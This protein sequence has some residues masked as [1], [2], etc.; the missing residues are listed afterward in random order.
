MV[1]VT[2]VEGG[3]EITNTGDIP[4]IVFVKSPD[5]EQQL[6]LDVGESVP[7][8][9]ITGPIEVLVVGEGVDATSAGH[10]GTTALFYLVSLGD[11]MPRAEQL[12]VRC[13]Q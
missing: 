2:E 3:I 4:V 9:G 10:L 13:Y 12:N 5:G 7:D 6:E 11:V 1:T 8:K